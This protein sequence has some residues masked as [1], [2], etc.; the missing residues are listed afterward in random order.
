MSETKAPVPVAG[1]ET[2]PSIDAAGRLT[3]QQ[4]QDKRKV[5]TLEYTKYGL[6]IMFFW[7]LWGDLVFTLMESVVPS[8][9]PLQLER[10]GVEKKWI[11]FMMVTL[12]S[13]IN[14]PMVPLISFRSDRT[15]SRM[16]RRIPYI[17]ATIPFVCAALLLMGHTDSLGAWVTSSDIGSKVGLSP[18]ATITAMMA[19][20]IVVWDFSN[21]FV[22]SVFWYLFA[23]VI[24]KAYMGRFMAAFRLVGAG[25]GAL[26]QA[27][28]FGR[29]ETNTREI[30]I[31]AAVLYLV[32]FG[33]MCWRVKEG[34]YPP[35]SDVAEGSSWLTRFVDGIK[36]YFKE[37]FTHPLYLAFFVS[38]STW[39]MSNACNLYKI[40]FYKKHVGLTLDQMGKVGSVMG[41]IGFCIIFPMGWL[42]DKIHPMRALILA[43]CFIIPATFAGYFIDSLWFYIA[44]AAAT[45]PFVG[46]FDSA[47]MPLMVQL[48]PR[49][50]YGQFASANSMMRSLTM[51]IFGFLGG[52]FVDWAT[53]TYGDRGYALTFLWQGTF[54][55]VGLICMITV[56]VYWRRYGGKNFVAES[57]ESLKKTA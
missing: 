5:G 12:T 41:I 57:I 30:Y 18:A 56:Y 38:K 48:L 35:P 4:D 52:W 34:Q 43:T 9:M 45:M 2:V 22:N 16:G 47:D 39:A 40:F 44:V 21:V 32:G 46:L 37:C 28:V 7:M 42:V 53:T 31:G 20:L 19:V 27:F 50:Q 55:V 17:M 13:M 15:R 51:M 6:F 26:F 23:D 1:K 11:G 24:P 14:L 8:S 3:Q 33:L 36:L 29:L 49:A 54:Q 10:L 25:A